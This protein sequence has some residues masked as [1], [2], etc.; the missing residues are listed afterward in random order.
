MYPSN[1]EHCLSTL[2]IPLLLYFQ[3]L[4]NEIENPGTS[5]PAELTILSITPQPQGMSESTLL[6]IS[7]LD[8]RATNWPQS[9]PNMERFQAKLEKQLG[10][11]IDD[12]KQHGKL[13]AMVLRKLYQVSE[14]VSRVAEANQTPLNAPTTP[15]ITTMR[16][17]DDYLA[18]IKRLKDAEFKEKVVNY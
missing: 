9:M 6:D 18:F 1:F 4:T 16:W 13:L 8:E 15:P 5:L 14:Q 10:G 12:P 17:E 2:R 11:S 3:V 7:L